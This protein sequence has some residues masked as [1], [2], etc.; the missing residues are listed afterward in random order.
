MSGPSRAWS[1]RHAFASSPDLAATTKHVLHTL[2]MF[3]NEV[4]EGC[5]P[6]VTD[7]C[8]YS[9][10]DKKTVLKHL[11]LAREAGWIAVSQMGFRGQKWKRN[12]YAARWPDRDLVSP[13]L[14]LDIDD[15]GGGAAPPPSSVEMA[16]ESGVEGGGIEGS[17]VVEHV[18][19]D[20]T[21]PE[22][23]PV[24]SPSERERGREGQETKPDDPR[25][26]EQ[27]VKR[28]AER[29]KWP[30]WA[31]SSTDWAVKQF[32]KLSDAE[33]SEAE[34]FG[35]IY[36]GHLGASALSIGTYFAERKWRDLPA[37]VRE[38][39]AEMVAIEAPAFG[40]AW[41]ATVI[42][43]LFKPP[44]GQIS[45]LTIYERGQVKAGAAIEA[46]LM[47]EKRSKFGWPAVSAIYE[48]ARHGQGI[49][50]ASSIEPLAALMEALWPQRDAE[51]IEAW[52]Q[53]FRRRDWPWLPDYRSDK[54]L[55][56]PAGGP[57]AG[58]KAF[59]QA[60]ND[61]EGKTHDGGARAAAAE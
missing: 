45:G 17:K 13:C 11:A 32:A 33:R 12:Q 3:M 38:P 46:E 26:F 9:G 31:N 51:T 5:Y 43:R 47:R 7:I 23:S 8:L 54:P 24:T 34:H 25:K 44:N 58:M 14:P 19:Q 2:G 40:K 39:P 42:E 35:P 15:E 61:R 21:S 28:L 49:T 48:R 59:E 1:W 18:H 27:R 57:L 37:D 53:E 6:S 55:F 50:V 56:L 22:T 4:G 30:G 41:I 60:L 29:C 36:T 10:L 16:V 20:K 52:K